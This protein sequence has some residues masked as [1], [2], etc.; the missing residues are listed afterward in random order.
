[1]DDTMKARILGQNVG[2]G[3]NHIE[4]L[5]LENGLWVTR[6]EEGEI[7][8]TRTQEELDRISAGKDNTP[9]YAYWVDY[10]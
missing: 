2:H 9:A 7:T 1:M 10:D 4:R 3:V 6:N 5:E 8:F